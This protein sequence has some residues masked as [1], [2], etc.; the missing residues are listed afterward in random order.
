MPRSPL[1]RRLIRIAFET[2][3]PEVRRGILAALRLAYSEDF[4]KSVEGQEYRNPETDKLVKFV[5][6]PAD[7]QKKLYQQ[8]QSKKK[9]EP[10]PEKPEADVDPDLEN[11]EEPKAKKPAGKHKE[12][13]ELRGAGKKKLSDPVKIDDELK[14]L[15]TPEGMDPKNRERAGK[16]L[17]EASYELLNMLYE[18]TAKALDKPDGKVMKSLLKSGYTP[19]ALEK[20]QSQ[21]KKHLAD[22]KGRQYT[23]D[24][25]EIANAH[26]LEG[27]DADELREFKGD[28][29]VH[30]KKLTPQELMQKFLK[31]AKP[32]TRDR[33]QGM[34][35]GDFMA[36]YKAIMAESGED[37]ADLGK[38]ARELE[39]PHDVMQKALNDGRLADEDEDDEESGSKAG[40]ALSAEDRE[41][42]RLAHG[43]RSTAVRR[44]LLSLL[45]R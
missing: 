1:E 5:S 41:I 10:K 3:D 7:E 27:D 45:G 13:K 8:W 11:D 34:P 38:M 44:Q 21:L 43:A 28:K 19:E 35:I 29:P 40:S 32:E 14:S 20:A 30:G 18:R 23:K 6:L 2:R 12:R 25:L 42:L 17:A 9:D 26:D 16:Q 4:L 37:D 36:M 24:V 33:M 15:L 39:Q 22:T 31:H